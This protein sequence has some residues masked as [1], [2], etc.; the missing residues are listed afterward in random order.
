[1]SCRRH[2]RIYILALSRFVRISPE[3]MLLAGVAISAMFSGATTL[4]QYFSN[5]VQLTQLMF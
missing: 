1:M 3:A 2:G 5:D 4:I